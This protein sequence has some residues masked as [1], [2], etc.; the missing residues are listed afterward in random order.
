MKVRD[1]IKELEKCDQDSYVIVQEY[2][3]ADD[4]GRVLKTIKKMNVKDAGVSP[5]SAKIIK[6]SNV[7]LLTALK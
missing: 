3:G 4:I 1:L 2:D 5:A 6:R 7:V